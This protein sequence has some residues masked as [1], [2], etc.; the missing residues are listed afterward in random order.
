[1]ILRKDFLNNYF[2][3]SSSINFETLANLSLETSD[4]I[5]VNTNLYDEAGNEIIKK[6]II[7]EIELVYNGSLKQKI[8][9]H[10]VNL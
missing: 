6:A 4:I 9:A 8:K 7:V 1:M 2:S 5:E 3:N 10:G